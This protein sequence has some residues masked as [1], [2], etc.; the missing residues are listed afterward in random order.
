[1]TEKILFTFITISAFVLLACSNESP[2]G[3]SNERIVQPFKSQTR[4]SNG[5]LATEFYSINGIK[6]GVYKEWFPSGAIQLERIYKM[7]TI[8]SEKL[9]T[10]DGE[11]IKNIVIKDGRKYGLLYS[12][13]CMNGVAKNPENDSLIFE[14]KLQ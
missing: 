3:D 8:S 11:I 13:F 5:K 7:G 14:S 9:Y 10:L 6:D 2:I 4:H 12:S 1:M